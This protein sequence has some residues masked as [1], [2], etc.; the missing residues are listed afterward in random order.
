MLSSVDGA[1]DVMAHIGHGHPVGH[2]TP[3]RQTSR[4]LG[5]L[6]SAVVVGGCV[7]SVAGI[8]V[9]LATHRAVVVPP[10]TH[11]RPL[12]AH[13]S[14]RAPPQ[15]GSK[16]GWLGEVVVVGACVDSVAGIVGILITGKNGNVNGFQEGIFS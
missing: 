8:V 15:T 11:T 6:G 14:P 5:H 10:S 13:M 3:P 12:R 2:G 4:A 16:G 7:D 9:S 1:V